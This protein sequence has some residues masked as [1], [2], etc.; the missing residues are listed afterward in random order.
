MS[1]IAHKST[2]SL[3]DTSQGKSN[4]INY[5]SINVVL[6]R[7]LLEMDHALQFIIEYGISFISKL[8]WSLTVTVIAWPWQNLHSCMASQGKLSWI[9]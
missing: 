1:L 5:A 7:V 8:N 6:L 3:P 9:V 2:H 4:Q